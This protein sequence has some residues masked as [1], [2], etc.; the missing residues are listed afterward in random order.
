[1]TEY[2]EENLNVIHHFAGG[3]YAKEMTINDIGA[4][5]HQHKHHF[6]HM[7]ILAKGSVW[8]EVNGHITQHVAP[9]VLNIKAGERHR[10]WAIEAPVKWYCIHAT[11]CEDPALVDSVIVKERVED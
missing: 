8:L 11:D 4:G 10:I 5:M 9:A 2:D 3:V 6:D 7:S 1:M